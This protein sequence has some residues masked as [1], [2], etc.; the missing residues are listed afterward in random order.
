MQKI[1]N[2]KLQ[3]KKSEQKV[4]SNEQQAKTKTENS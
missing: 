4:M 2:K 3:A 1:T